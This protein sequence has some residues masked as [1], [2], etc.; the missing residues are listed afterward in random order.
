MLAR[1]VEHQPQLSRPSGTAWHVV[2]TAPQAE[3]TARE[4]IQALGFQ[5]Y[6]PVERTTKI[7]RRKRVEVVRPLFSRYLFVGVEPLDDWRHVLGVDG[8]E[9]VLRNNDAPSRVPAAWIEALRKIEEFGTFDRRK[10][11]PTP[12]RIG[13]M[14]R[15]SDGPFAGF[16]AAIEAFVAKLQST[17]KSQRAK[18]LVD[19]LGRHVAMELDIVA[20][21]KL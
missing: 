19:F 21:E 4:G 18:V 5:A 7:R 8:V 20:L 9:D 3:G 13:E 12:F 16:N 15:V 11:A 6:M 17:T 14:V 1:T 2:Y 10:N